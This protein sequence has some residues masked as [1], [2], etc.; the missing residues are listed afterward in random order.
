MDMLSKIEQ[1]S[2]LDSEIKEKLQ[3]LSEWLWALVD[4]DGL[5]VDVNPYNCSCEEVQ[6]WFICNDVLYINLEYIDEWEG[7]DS[8]TNI[9]IPTS[10]LGMSKE[11]IK[12]LAIKNI[13]DYNEHELKSN[14]DYIKTMAIKLGLIKEG[15]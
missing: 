12:P 2:K 7:Y 15:E 13:L 4:E 8:H 11:E 14:F 3:E 10:W 5:E 9:T 6:T 1:H